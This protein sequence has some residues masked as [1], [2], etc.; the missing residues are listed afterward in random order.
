TGKL[1]VANTESRNH[2][3]F[4]GPGQGESQDD[5]HGSTTVR[6]HIAESR[7]TVL[8]PATGAVRPVHLNAHINYGECCAPTPNAESETSLA[9]PTSLAISRKRDFRGKVKDEQDLYL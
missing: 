2:V 8:E 5:G 7:I 9:F 1:F 6:G 4:E 3:R